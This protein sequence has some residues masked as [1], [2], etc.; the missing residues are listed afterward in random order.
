M[1]K[2]RKKNYKQNKKNLLF[3]FIMLP[4]LALTVYAML[5]PQII[6]QFAA[7]VSAPPLFGCLHTGAADPTLCGTKMGQEGKNL[8]K[9]NTKPYIGQNI[10]YNDMVSGSFTYK[11]VGDQP[12]KIKNFGI[13]AGS[14]KK[15]YVAIFE[16]LEGPT[17]LNP[18]QVLSSKE[19][20]YRFKTPDP[21]E[22]WVV[23]PGITNTDGQPLPIKDSATNI[24]VNSACTALR[25]KP[26]TAKD[27]SHIKAL[28][29]K[30]PKNILCT[31]RQYC[32]LFKGGQCSGPVL[33]TERENQQCDAGIVLDQKEQDVLEQLCKTYPDSD[34]CKDFCKR[35]I[36]SKLCPAELLWFDPSG[37]QVFPQPGKYMADAG[38]NN[39][40]QA[41]AGIATAPN[42]VNA[43]LVCPPGQ[44]ESG[45]GV[46]S[47]MC[48]PA[49]A[50]PPPATPARPIVSIP[51]TTIKPKPNPNPQ[52][53][54]TLLKPS[55][56]SHT[57]TLAGA[58]CDKTASG[59]LPVI[60][61]CCQTRCFKYTSAPLSRTNCPNKN[62]TSGCCAVGFTQMGG[63][64]VKQG[65]SAPKPKPNL[66]TI[67]VIN[68][69]NYQ[70]CNT[71]QTQAQTQAQA[72]V[73]PQMTFNPCAE[74]DTGNIQDGRNGAPPSADQKKKDCDYKARVN[75]AKC[76][77]QCNGDSSCQSSCNSTAASRIAAC[78][79]L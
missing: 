12:I 76:S 44:V 16:P 18:G 13:A 74:L 63:I 19:S 30:D 36:G 1:A 54:V 46:T 53:P 4:I 37:K 59:T 51:G 52:K 21:S 56:A 29:A 26:L 5:Q 8:L 69:P 27:K 78:N 66:V 33:G 9:V 41:V 58:C 42:D 17:T 70:P 67:P 39:N 62:A 24:R 71:A 68:P 38:T 50:A 28:C 60:N 35:A 22:G 65:S 77:N 14:F 11:N 23:G 55:C 79:S 32:E 64:C 45:G 48:V 31:S 20:S 6:Q 43:L 3:F 15:Y 73:V 25:V 49:P 61:N 57:A 40:P 10:Y 47:N 72:D 7:G 75:L 34:A 2:S